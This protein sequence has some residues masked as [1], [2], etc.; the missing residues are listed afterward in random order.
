MAAFFKEQSLILTQF[1]QKSGHS[2]STPPVN[3]GVSGAKTFPI[4]GDQTETNLKRKMDK[5]F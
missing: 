4:N 1:L 3:R 2:D 5:A